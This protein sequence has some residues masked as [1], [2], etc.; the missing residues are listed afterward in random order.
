MT[1]DRRNA[2][3]AWGSP[4]PHCVD[5]GSAAGHA[6]R[7]IGNMPT[8]RDLWLAT[9]KVRGMGSK[10]KIQRLALG[11]MRREH[12]TANPVAF[13]VVLRGTTSGS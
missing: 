10:G 6:A 1:D 2:Q 7:G 8:S 13:A 11:A 3:L 4:D 5:R 12:A 9:A